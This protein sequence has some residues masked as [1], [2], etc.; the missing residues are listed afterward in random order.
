MLFPPFISQVLKELMFLFQFSSTIYHIAALAE[1]AHCVQVFTG[2]NSIVIV[3]LDDDNFLQD[4]NASPTVFFFS[5]LDYSVG[6][7]DSNSRGTRRN[8]LEY[9]AKK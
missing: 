6:M 5:L 8:D 3:K 9:L 2:V 4:L 7:R 1:R